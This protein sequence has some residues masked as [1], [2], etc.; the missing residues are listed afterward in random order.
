MRLKKAGLGGLRDGASWRQPKRAVFH[1]HR[2]AAG[3][4]RDRLD[5]VQIFILPK[6]VH[7]TNLIIGGD[8]SHRREM[9][10]DGDPGSSVYR[11][12]KPLGRMVGGGGVG[13]CRIR[14][15]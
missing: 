11:V 9:K 2:G 12:E 14:V 4:H 7:P 13:R 15:L 10:R 5:G 3:G 6:K 8:G 1:E